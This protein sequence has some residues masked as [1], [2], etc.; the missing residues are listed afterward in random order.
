MP[1]GA[2]SVYA[3]VNGPDM[4]SVK[5]IS[6][7]ENIF[8]DMEQHNLSDAGF[9]MVGHEDCDVVADQTVTPTITVR[10]LAARVVLR[11][12][13]CH[14]PS[15]YADMTVN[16]VFL[17]NAYS[18]QTVAGEVDRMQNVNG[19][20]SGNSTPIGKSGVTGA[21]PDYFYRSANDVI[22]VNSTHEEMY[23]MYCQPNDTDNFTCL[24][25]LVT[26]GDKQYYYRVPLSY[27]L[28]ANVTCSVDV[29]IINLGSLLPPDG[30]VQKGDITAVIKVSDWLR[31]EEYDIKF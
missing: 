13:S 18:L 7:L 10:R 2:K 3:V 14:I 30:T 8:Y 21:C 9:F 1:V 27:G 12:V 28:R 22:N 16:S 31:G 23:Y 6:Q 26:I 19:Y 29:D 5:S 25:L 15:Q 24:Y 4:S 17:G 20:V 11:S